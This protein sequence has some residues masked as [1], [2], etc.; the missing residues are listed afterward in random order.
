MQSLPTAHNSA[1][2]REQVA[3]APYA[4][5]VSNSL[6]SFSPAIFPKPNTLNVQRCDG[7]PLTRSRPRSPPRNGIT[8]RTLNPNSSTAEPKYRRNLVDDLVVG[9]QLTI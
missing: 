7:L 5:L 4:D 8:Y 1:R 3:S 6:V 2:R 9:P